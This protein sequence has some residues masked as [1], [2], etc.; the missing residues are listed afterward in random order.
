MRLARGLPGGLWLHVPH[1]PADC[2]WASGVLHIT[3][4]S[5][6]SCASRIQFWYGSPWLS[7]TPGL[8]LTQCCF[9]FGWF[10]LNVFS[11]PS[12]T[13]MKGLSTKKVVSERVGS[14]AACCVFLTIASPEEGLKTSPFKMFQ[15][16]L[17]SD[18]N[19]TALLTTTAVI[20]RLVIIC[21]TQVSRAGMSHR[22][23]LLPSQR[24]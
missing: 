15:L 24:R 6:V 13:R 5:L 3:A 14:R 12:G 21:L 8:F 19:K 7:T 23:F 10:V 22:F 16:I 17:E 20:T 1:S 11:V 2:S 4:S 18:L 9:H